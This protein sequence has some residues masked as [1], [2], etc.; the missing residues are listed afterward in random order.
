MLYGMV[1][2]AFD[3]TVRKEVIKLPNLPASFEGLKIVQIS[4]IHSGSFTST[5]PFEKAI[6]LIHEQKP[7]LVFFTGDLVNNIADEVDDYIQV[8][9]TI[10]SRN[11]CIYCKFPNLLMC[12]RDCCRC[13]LKRLK[14]R[15][16]LRYCYI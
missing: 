10:R 15:L 5:N 9:S 4:D 12:C 16:G 8:L 14:C 6:K 11:I 7:D 13:L 1:K 2:T 3:F